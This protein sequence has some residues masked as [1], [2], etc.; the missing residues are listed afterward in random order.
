MKVVVIGGGVVGVTTAYQLQQDGHE[1]TLIE[2]QPQVAEE[3]SWGNAGMVA[4]GHSFAWSSPQAPMILLKSLVKKNQALRFKPSLDPRLWTWSLKF[5]AQCT[6]ER[7]RINTLRK[8]RLATYSQGV[9]HEV[10]ARENIQF[11][12][13]ARGIM[14]FYRDEASLERGIAHMKILAD[15]GQEMRTISRD[16]I[17]KLDPSLASAAHKI[18]GAVYCPT[19]ETGDCNKFTNGLAKLCIERGAEFRTG[20]AVTR[21]NVSGNQVAS[22]QT[23]KGEVKGDLYVL[24]AG[25]YSPILARP[26]GIDLPIYPVKGYSL[27]IPIGNHGAAPTIASV[28]ENNLVAITRMG[29]RVR[30]TATAEFAGYNTSHKPDD[31][32]FMKGIVQE[33]YPDGADYDRAFMWAGLRPMTPT[34]MPI[35]GPSRYRNLFFNTGH[36]HIGWTMSNG[37]ARIAADMIAGRTPAIPLD[38]LAA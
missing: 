37:S 24:S 18:A 15:D 13:N 12:N 34:N 17:L 11:D 31:F 27:T 1:V 6:E 30:V 7:A 8:H 35:I 14:Y 22:V 4:P 23:D 28:D 20:T 36:G 3:T 10:V 5:L 26:I 16:E 21:I 32:T 9:L 38:G 19:D 25:N 33:L 2:K 29:D